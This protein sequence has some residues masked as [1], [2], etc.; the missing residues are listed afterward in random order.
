MEHAD[1]A[2]AILSHVSSP[3]YRPV[4]PRVIAKQLG[5]DSDQRD[6]LKRT[7]KRLVKK[8]QLAY[9][10]NHL[11]APVQAA[12]SATVKKA[13]AGK[14]TAQKRRGD[15]QDLVGV[16][17]RT[18][19]G[20]GFVRPHGATRDASDRKTDIFISADRTMDAASG[21]TVLVRL[22]RQ[23]DA[24]R[25][26]PAGEIVEIVERETNQF[27][28]TYFES[29]GN[30]YVQVDGKVFSRPVLVGDPG[31]KNAQTDDKVV[32]EMVRFP[33]QFHDGEGVIVEVLGARGR[34]ALI[35]CR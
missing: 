35:R 29:A 7:I 6:E 30:A 27:V 34:R 23:R 2:S 20:H 16:F 26:N 1:L 5:L 3:N 19:A 13:T 24:R 12:K 8:G 21:D 9:G 15:G 14:P 33:S 17:R 32:F 10:S 28:G 4:K 25:S 31:A 11:I 18:G 22:S